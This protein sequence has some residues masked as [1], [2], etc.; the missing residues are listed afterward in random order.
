MI[1]S[2]A[3]RYVFVELPRTG[4]TAISYE[5]R[6]HYGG[7]KVLA[8]HA[9]YRDFLRHA[10]AD[11]RGYFA[12]SS[13]RNPL[14]VAVSRYSH[15]KSNPAGRFTDPAQL[16]KRR[17]LPQRMENRI[18]AWTHRTDASFGDFLRTW[19][20]LPF[21][22]WASLDHH[23]LDAIL[24]FENLQDDFEAVLGRL[25][26]EMVRPIPVVNVTPD[27]NREYLSAY[28]PDLVDHAVW[29]FGP[30]MREWGY[31]FPAE[32]GPRKVPLSSRLL[33]RALR[34]VRWFYWE[35][36][37]PSDY[38]ERQKRARWSEH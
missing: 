10:T 20:R 38:V 35:G 4:S 26:I 11:E 12:F 18:H 9:T 33:M 22:T 34:P 31:E 25:G 7:E 27:R 6:E 13:I 37:R 5:L 36:L 19:Y 29:V 8:K 24:R 3:H 15:I 2:H 14:D 17:S 16:A 21:D 28:T 23:R 30:Y 32:W 1:I